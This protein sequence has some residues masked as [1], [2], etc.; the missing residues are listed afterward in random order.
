MSKV[1]VD[2]VEIAA[3]TDQILALVPEMKVVAPTP[4]ELVTTGIVSPNDPGV[5][6]ASF[7]ENVTEAALQG[8]AY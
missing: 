4:E 3:A 7:V 8:L 6:L 1:T 2:P 5:L